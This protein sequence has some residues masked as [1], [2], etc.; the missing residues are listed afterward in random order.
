MTEGE[1][2]RRTDRGVERPL[3]FSLANFHNLGGQ[4]KVFLLLAS[5]LFSDFFSTMALNNNGMG[6]WMLPR[7]RSL[8]PPFLALSFSLRRMQRRYWK[9]SKEEGCHRERRRKEACL[10]KYTSPSPLSSSTE[11]LLLPLLPHL[12]NI[13]NLTGTHELPDALTNRRSEGMMMTSTG[14]D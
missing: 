6:G 12:C 4:S 9:C 10:G 3:L 2:V 13:S 8:L 5:L 11:L 14:L 7:P 1:S